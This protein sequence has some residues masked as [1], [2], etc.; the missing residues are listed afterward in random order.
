MSQKLLK[1]VTGKILKAHLVEGELIQGKEIGIRIPNHLIPLEIVKETGVPLISTSVHD[2]DDVL[3]Y[4]TDPEL[5]YERYENLVDMV[6]AGGYGNNVASTV[7]NCVSGR[8]EIVR[9]GIGIT[10]DL[11]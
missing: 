9:Q 8:P 10:D 7:I 11:F 2:N 3:E 1:T 4:T 6:V 5:I